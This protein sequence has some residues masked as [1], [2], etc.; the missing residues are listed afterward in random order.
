MVAIKTSKGITDRKDIRNIIMQGTVPTGLLCTTTIDKPTKHS[1]ENKN[2]LYKYKGV[3][4]VPPLM[5]VDDVAIISECGIASVAM[6]ATVNS[7]VET[8]KL[9]LILSKCSVIHVGNDTMCC[10]QLKVHGEN[11]HEE[12]SAKYLGDIFHKSGKA[13]FN[14]VERQNKAYAILAEILQYWKMSH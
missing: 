7:F 3:V 13:K 14:I 10:P 11:M 8:K 9:K 1:Y 2:L 6:N 4:D 12:N 5:M